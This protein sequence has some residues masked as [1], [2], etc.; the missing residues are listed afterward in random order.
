MVIRHCGARTLPTRPPRPVQQPTP[1][2]TLDLFL[3]DAF[4]LTQQVRNQ[5][6]HRTLFS[7]TMQLSHGGIP[8]LAG[9]A[10]AKAV[11]YALA[12]SPQ[13]GPDDRAELVNS[14]LDRLRYSSEATVAPLA[15]EAFEQARPL[16]DLQQADRLKA[17]SLKSIAQL[18]GWNLLP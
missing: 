1:E 16:T 13:A 6:L 8:G 11:T 18:E 15:R 14:A 17:H 7:A 4:P 3:Q 2:V 12:Q 5:D 9:V 10:L